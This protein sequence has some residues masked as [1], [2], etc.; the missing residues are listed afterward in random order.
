MDDTGYR[1]D[2]Q[3][4]NEKT[5]KQTALTKTLTLARREASQ[6]DIDESTE[7]F[8]NFVRRFRNSPIS[9]TDYV[10]CFRRFIH[11]CNLPETKAR[12]LGNVDI[13]E[14][15]NTD[16]LLL[17]GDTRRIQNLVKHY[18]DYQYDRGI[19]PVSMKSYYNAIK[20]F[21]ESNEISLN[22]SLIKKEDDNKTR[23]LNLLDSY[24]T[25]RRLEEQYHDIETY[26]DEYLEEQGARKW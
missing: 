14:L 12:I 10:N 5:K 25:S 16:L 26:G 7:S 6:L 4:E 23:D 24:L 9:K 22:W 19:S 13:G 8:R 17:D 1:C 2:D 3:N 21:Y 15:A 20:H 11:Y 18:V